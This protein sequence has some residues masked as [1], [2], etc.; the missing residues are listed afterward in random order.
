MMLPLTL[1]VTRVPLAL[2]GAGAAALSRLVSLDAAGA[3]RVTVYAEAPD[4]DLAAAAGD[5][6]VRRL[7][8]PAD[9]A[10]ARALMVAGLDDETAC[11]LATTARAMG[12]LVNV[13]DRKAWCDFHFA[14]VIRRGDLV[15]A[16]S[17]NGKSPGLARRLRRFLEGLI[18]PEWGGRVEEVAA[19]RQ[20][21]RAAGADM[22]TV[23]RLSDAHIERRGW[24]SRASGR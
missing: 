5:R 24:L 1:D 7:P 15:L 20:L 19:R 17:T 2:T 13:E 12:V 10:E 4:A 6:L 11:D 23:G 8:A 9:L 18:G 22:A 14:S 21:W 16:I 3:T